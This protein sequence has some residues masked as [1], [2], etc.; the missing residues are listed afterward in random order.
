MGVVNLSFLPFCIVKAGLQAILMAPSTTV[1]RRDARRRVIV[2]SIE[3]A[4]MV[5][6]LPASPKRSIPS[7]DLCGFGMSSGCPNKQTQT[8]KHQRIAPAMA[9]PKLIG[10]RGFPPCSAPTATWQSLH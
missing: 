4:V 9:S 3:T 10:A 1:S 5:T 8:P 6:L 7:H 2:Q